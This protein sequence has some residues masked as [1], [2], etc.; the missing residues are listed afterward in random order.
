MAIA[1]MERDY[2]AP[3][4]I[5]ELVG[6]DGHTQWCLSTHRCRP[7]F[8]SLAID[9]KS[10]LC[11]FE[12]PD[13]E[14]LRIASKQMDMPGQARVWGANIHYHPDDP[15]PEGPVMRDGEAALAIVQRSFGKPEIFEELQAMEDAKASC[16]TMHRVRFVKTFF[17][18]DRQRMAC[19]YAAPD[20]EA[21][22][23]ASTMTGLP[24]DRIMRAAL[25]V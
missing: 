20:V 5:G 11:V 1:V 17:S 2:A 19:L 6:L 21:V 9:G 25:P 3:I 16:L 7:L 23:K 14:A 22:R 4:T 24:F 15:Q 8:H 10:S 13:A 12:C 18:L